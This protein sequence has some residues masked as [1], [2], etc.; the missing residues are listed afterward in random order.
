MFAG[1][2]VLGGGSLLMDEVSYLFD[3]FAG[4]GPEVH[5]DI[6]L[7]AVDPVIFCGVRCIDAR[8]EL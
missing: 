1:S 5:Q 6:F 7:D 8:R 4:A 3:I 2:L